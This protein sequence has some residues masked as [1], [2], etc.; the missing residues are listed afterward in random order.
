MRFLVIG[1][2]MAF[3]VANAGVALAQSKCDAGVTKAAGKKAACKAGVIAKA[4]QKGTTPDAA[5]LAKCAAKFDKACNKAKGNTKSPCSAQTQACSAIEAE[6]D[7]C[8]ASISGSP[9]AA[10]LN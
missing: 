3:A 4:Q 9:S 8:V 2:V 1:A 7:A 6:V 5:K 10:F